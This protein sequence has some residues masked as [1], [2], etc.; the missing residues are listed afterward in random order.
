MRQVEEQSTTQSVPLRLSAA[1]AIVGSLAVAGFRL[2]HGDLPA[3]DVPAALHF[4]TEHNFYAGVH[5]GTIIGV[6]VWG[7]GFVT[8]AATL[9][10]G[11]GRVLGRLG[12]ASVLV[13]TA[14]FC[15]EHS[16]DGVA[17]QA[18]AEAWAAASP[19][20]QA[21]L[22]LAAQTAFQMLRGPSLIAILLLWGM[23]PVLFSLAVML[24]DY[25]VWLGWAG[26]TVGAT[27]VIASA[28]LLLREDLFPGVIL[29]G[30]LASIVAPLWSLALGI[31]MWRRT[32]TVSS[33]TT[34]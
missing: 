10:H 31:A 22:A 14:I 2:N 18:L 7:A 13:G 4:I 6:L 28:A 26:L 3:A 24:E 20:G 29:Y 34:S 21:D 32:L 27:T 17:G 5:V 23:A 19:A 11:F 16:I 9:M 25:P 15:V 8:F 30:L 1:C 12:A 33:A